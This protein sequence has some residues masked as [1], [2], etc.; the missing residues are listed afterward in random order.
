RRQD[1]QGVLAASVT[2]AG[3]LIPADL[4]RW[5]GKV[6]VGMGPGSLFR[7]LSEISGEKK[8]KVA[9]RVQWSHGSHKL[10]TF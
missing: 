8:N 6:G 10:V 2:V 7:L 1:C 3:V 4:T 5:F 9:N